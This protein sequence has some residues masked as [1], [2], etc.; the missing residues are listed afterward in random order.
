MGTDH[1][2]LL[3]ISNKATTE[4]INAAFRKEARRY[5][6]DV[7][8]LPY[9]KDFFTK[10]VDAHQTLKDK[11][12]RE[13]YDQQLIVDYFQKSVLN[14]AE[15]RLAHIPGQSKRLGDN[16]WGWR[17]GRPSFLNGKGI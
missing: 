9:A 13:E 1:Y 7:C 14:P 8:K 2:R 10:L 17:V 16:K 5:H 15:E 11:Q 4:E 3:G 6:P 12:K